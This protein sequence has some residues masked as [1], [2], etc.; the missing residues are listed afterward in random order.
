I[1]TQYDQ[2][3]YGIES[4]GY[5]YSKEVNTKVGEV[6]LLRVVAYRLQRKFLE[7]ISDEEVNSENLK[8]VILN[9][10]KREDITIAFRI[11]RA[12]V[13]GNLTIIWK[14]LERKK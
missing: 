12:D 4:D 8:F 13:N 5:K 2:I 9:Q 14:E 11:I 1:K 10:A 6:Y 7:Q 3:F